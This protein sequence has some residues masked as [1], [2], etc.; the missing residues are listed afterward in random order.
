[1]TTPVSQDGTIKACEE[2]IFVTTLGAEDQA[3]NVSAWDA[4]TGNLLQTFRNGSASPNT[5]CLLA[6]ES[7]L[8]A[9]ITKPIIHFWNMLRQSQKHHKIICGGKVSS[10]SLTPDSTFIAAGIEDKIHL[11]QTNNGELFSV[12]S[13]SSVEVKRLKFSPTGEYL[14]AA[15]RDGAVT[16]WDLQSVVYYD[17]LQVED[18]RPINTFLGHA[19]EVT[20]FHISLTNRIASSS[21]DFTVRLWHLL[22]KEEVKMF[23]LGAPVMSVLMDH[24][25][26][27][28]YAGDVN[29]NVYAIDLHYQPAE[30]SI[31]LDLCEENK[32]FT[33]H[34]AHNA[35]VRC[36]ALTRDQSKLVTASSD[37]TVKVWTMMSPVS[38]LVITLNEQVSNLLLVPTPKAFVSPDNKPKRML[39]ILKRHVHGTEAEGADDD[40]TIEVIAVNKLEVT[41]APLVQDD[42]VETLK[43]K[44]NKLKKAN[45]EMYEFA[46]KEIVK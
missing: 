38:P 21:M 12:L 20:D 29:G 10:L 8:S 9:S 3:G 18:H 1:M 41:A 34:K 2:V 45:D 14:V 6:G 7:L 37:K 35:A 39:G 13:Y 33:F 42:T 28:L 32:G 5:L 26:Q 11:W 44:A 31:H 15:Y 25:E 23:E 30:H 22:Y 40:V 19:G 4:R 43:Q 24:C 36:M 16:V 27:T 46:L 17:P